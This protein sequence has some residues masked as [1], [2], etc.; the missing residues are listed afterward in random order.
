MAKKVSLKDIA[1]KVGV[2][3]ALVSYVLNNQKEGRIGKAVAQ[4][5]RDT[6][7]ELNYRPNQ[8]AR[9]L[10]TSKTNTIGLLVS[11]IANPFFSALARI[12]EDEADKHHFTVIFGSSDENPQKSWTLMETLL[13]RQVDGL[14]IAATTHTEEQIECLLQQHVPFVLVDRYFP[15]L[16]TNYVV[17]DNHRAAFMATSYLLDCG[18]TKIGL[19]THHSDLFHMQERVRGYKDAMEQHGCA[20]LKYYIQEA[21]ATELKKT[22]EQSVDKLLSSPSKVDAILFTNNL[23]AIYA[24]KYIHSKGIKIPDDLALVC[25]DEID[26]MD[27]FYAPLTYLR[28]PMQQIGR[29]ATRI[30]LDAIKGNTSTTQ[31][32]LEAELVIR[33]SVRNII[34]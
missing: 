29:E 6:A 8:I 16:E 1:E 27:F 5:I 30:L 7:K 15:A 33:A 9:S 31:I 23:V 26:A 11:D 28:Q 12:I 34:K 19:I 10:K 4:K 2:S 14:I 21:D 32:K 24:V 13:N 20:I 18:Y 17:L 3:V 22:V 25:F